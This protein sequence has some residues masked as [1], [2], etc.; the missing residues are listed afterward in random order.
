[1]LKKSSKDETLEKKIEAAIMMN[2]LSLIMC[3]LTL[4]VNCLGPHKEIAIK[5]ILQEFSKFTDKM[6]LEHDKISKLFD[7]AHEIVTSLEI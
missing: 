3:S 1:M 2:Y 6:T 4:I 7:K 5:E